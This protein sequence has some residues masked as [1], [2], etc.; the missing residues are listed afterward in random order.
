MKKIIGIVG[1]L[2]AGSYNKML[3]NAVKTAAEAKGLALTI[4]NFESIPFFNQDLEKNPPASVATLKEQ[5]K[6]ADAIIIATPEYNRS[7]PGVLKNATDWTSRPYG[8]N[9]WDGKL[10]ATIGASGGMTGAM[11]AQY[12]LK[13]VLLYLN[14]QVLGQPEFYL[15]LAQDKF[16]KN[17][18][19]TDETTK[20]KINELLDTLIKAMR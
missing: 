6:G 18:M 8:Q 13:Q 10:V 16:D 11:A 14:A 2:R 17:G 19:L 7:I 20:K 5:I 4:A 3:M 1:S 15:G 9:A 12:A